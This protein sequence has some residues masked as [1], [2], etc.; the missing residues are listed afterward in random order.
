MLAFKAAGIRG[1]FEI[2]RLVVPYLTVPPFEFGRHTEYAT[3][4][5]HKDPRFIAYASLYRLIRDGEWAE[6]VLARDPKW[7][8]KAM[9]LLVEKVKYDL[10]WPREPIPQDIPVDELHRLQIIAHGIATSLDD[11]VLDCH[12]AS[13]SPGES[14]FCMDLHEAVDKR[15]AY[16]K[17]CPQCVK[18]GTYWDG[19]HMK[20]RD[21]V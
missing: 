21:S 15:V 19:Q 11:F 6:M 4:P 7:R 10:A 9:L 1:H 16:D 8:A 14:F 3:C 17:R 20:R 18:N 12:H 5:A 13:N 2:G